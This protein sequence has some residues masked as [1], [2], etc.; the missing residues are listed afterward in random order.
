MASGVRS[1]GRRI[2]VYERA[3]QFELLRTLDR[4]YMWVSPIPQELLDRHGLVQRPSLPVRHKDVLIYRRQ[5]MLSPM[6]ELFLA[7]LARV[8]AELVPLAQ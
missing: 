6:D 7:E 4:A 5:Y 1:S 3:S 2:G 8:Q